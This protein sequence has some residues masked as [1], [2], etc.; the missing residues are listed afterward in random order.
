MRLDAW[1]KESIEYMLHLMFVCV[2]AATDIMD[3]RCWQELK[4][5]AKEKGLEALSEHAESLIMDTHA[6]ATVRAYEGA[7]G[8]WREW[9]DSHNFNALPADPVA[10][11]LDLVHSL[12]QSSSASAVSKAKAA[13]GWVYEKAC[14][15]LPFNSMV[16]QITTAAK[17]RTTRLPARKRP[18]SREQVAA[19][20]RELVQAAEG[21]SYP[22]RLAISTPAS[23]LIEQQQLQTEFSILSEHLSQT[24]TQQDTTFF[25]ITILFLA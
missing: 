9:A 6:A 5:M 14:L 18:F 16:E 15:P 20:V 13:I 7:Y 11:S 21:P 25:P 19:I 8:R 17:K 12:E 2:C 10:V 23:L 4:T 3:Q 22:T 1:C 24:E